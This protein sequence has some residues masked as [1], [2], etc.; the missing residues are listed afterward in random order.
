MKTPF[1]IL[2]LLLIMPALLF[3]NN[4]KFKYKKEKVIKKEFSV[5]ANATLKVDNSFGNVDIVT[6]SENRIEIVITITTEGNSED[7]TQKKLDEIDIEFSATASYVSAKTI[8]NKKGSR[9]WFGSNNNS[10]M[11][12]NYTI[13]MPITNSLDLSND[14]GS[15]NLTKLEGQA[16]ISCDY[17]QFIIGELMADENYLNFDYTSKST[18]EYMKSGKINADYSGFTLEK[19]ERID[20]NADYTSSNI[21]EVINIDYNCDYGEITVD[22]VTNL[23]GVGDY[24]SHRIGNVSG[25]LNINADYGSIKIDRIKSSAKNIVI[26][27]DYTSIKMG[28]EN[29]YKFNFNINLKYASFNGKDELTIRHSAVQNSSKKYS[30]FHGSENSRNTVNI[31]SEYGGIKLIKY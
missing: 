21:V 15:I 5:N 1:K 6:W 20:L 25:S 11:K 10:S 7:K 16:K 26:V 31:N 12:I 29:D 19:A 18:I 28:Y 3:A 17:G 27:A 2:I 23:E 13:K 30:G 9:N 8:F 24:I 22:N 14:Y 4:G